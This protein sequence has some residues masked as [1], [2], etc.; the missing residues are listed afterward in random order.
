MLRWTV[1]SSGAAQGEQSEAAQEQPGHCQEQPAATRSIPALVQEQSGA[2]QELP[3]AARELP[4]AAG[5]RLG[6]YV[7][8]G[9][10]AQGFRVLGRSFG[11]FTITR[12]V[13][14][15]FMTATTEAW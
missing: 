5:G 15:L 12:T 9:F 6:P 7:S 4:G 8:R 2:A 11:V 1:D 14:L 3:G 13:A 10:C